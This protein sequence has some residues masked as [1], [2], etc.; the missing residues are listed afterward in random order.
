[1]DN[2]TKWVIIFGIII[3]A[4]I[5]I[6]IV[7]TIQCWNVPIANKIGWCALQHMGK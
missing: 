5:I 1:M 6:N 3:L 2:D 4:I 7:I